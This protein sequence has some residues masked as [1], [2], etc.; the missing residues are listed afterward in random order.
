MF[1][2]PMVKCSAELVAGSTSSKQYSPLCIKNYEDL[3]VSSFVKY[4]NLLNPSSEVIKKHRQWV[5]G[6]WL[7]AICKHHVPLFHLADNVFWPTVMKDVHCLGDGVRKRG[8]IW[9]I[10][11]HRLF[12]YVFSQFSLSIIF[13]NVPESVRM[14]VQNSVNLCKLEWF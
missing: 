1:V 9:W 10:Q 2:V 13:S 11:N 7:S 12:L 5:I 6:R 3:L 8:R 4:C 14:F